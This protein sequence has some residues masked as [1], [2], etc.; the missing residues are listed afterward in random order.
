MEN[1]GRVRSILMEGLPAESVALNAVLL[2]Q[3]SQLSASS[4]E[5]P[6]TQPS[7]GALAFLQQ[8]RTP[9]AVYRP[10]NNK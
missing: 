10:G 5:L 9:I 3:L 2:L 4:Y 7:D 6:F 1:Y 8:K